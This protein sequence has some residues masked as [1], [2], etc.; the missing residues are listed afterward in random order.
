MW[1]HHFF[2]LSHLLKHFH[3]RDPSEFRNANEPD[4]KERFVFYGGDWKEYMRF[5]T[6]GELLWNYSQQT[7]K[8][9][10]NARGFW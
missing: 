1:V 7:Q 8:L 5:D 9:N 4:S 3:V 2:I 6:D 10:F